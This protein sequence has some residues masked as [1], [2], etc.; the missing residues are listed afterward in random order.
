MKNP[1]EQFEVSVIFS[2][3]IYKN[4]IDLTLTNIT[5][6]YFIILIFILFFMYLIIPKKTKK[7]QLN[8]NYIFFVSNRW[9]LLVEYLILAVLQII[10]D[11]FDDAIVAQKFV[12]FILSLFFFILLLNLIGLIPYS[13]SVTSHCFITFGFSFSVFVGATFIAIQKH[14]LKILQILIPVNASVV[15]AV[16]LILIELVSYFSRPFSL[17]L[18][19][20][21]NIMTGHCLLKVIVGFSWELLLISGVYGPL[22]HFI[23]V[24]ALILLIVLE[25]MVAVIQ[26]YVFIV[27]TCIYLNDSINLH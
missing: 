25:I 7:I 15:I 16:F 27:L 2:F 8:E 1:I 12:P 26:T 22:L 10:V 24:I 9:Q 5:I 11:N 20:F 21:I 19:L 17:G 13:I 18:R 23:P 4:K 14:K 6:T 3:E